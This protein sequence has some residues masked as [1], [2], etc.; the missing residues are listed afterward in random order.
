MESYTMYGSYT[1]YITSW[2][3]I[4][5]IVGSGAVTSSVFT[6]VEKS[7]TPVIL[8]GNFINWRSFFRADTLTS[9]RFQ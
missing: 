7:A 9:E 3:V 4:A 5:W 8:S 2:H 1:E 6:L